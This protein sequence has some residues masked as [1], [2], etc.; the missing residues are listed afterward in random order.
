MLYYPNIMKLSKL[1]LSA[2]STEIRNK[3][4]PIC[5]NCVHFIEDKSNYPYDPLP[6]NK[7]GRCKKFGE[8]NIISG[9]VEYDFAEK[10]RNDIKLCGKNGK[11]FKHIDE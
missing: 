11:E 4:L 10:C 8:I 2:F 9:V 6:N 7:Y 3:H 5:V 1:I